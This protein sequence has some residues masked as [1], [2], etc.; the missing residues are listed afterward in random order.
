MYPKR[1]LDKMTKIQ[2]VTVNMD[3]MPGHYN[4]HYF[5][6]FIGQRLL[7]LAEPKGNEDDCL[8]LFK[9][10]GEE[11]STMPI[12]YSSAFDV[13]VHML[14]SDDEW[15][16]L[17]TKNNPNQY[18]NESRIG[19]YFGAGLGL[20]GIDRF[21]LDKLNMQVEGKNLLERL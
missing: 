20:V 19:D 9:W 16:R 12:L 15:Y 17:Y 4:R 11:N 14:E 10:E 6:P 3:R 7:L 2:Y 21:M 8:C 18:M 5:T 1:T 13:L